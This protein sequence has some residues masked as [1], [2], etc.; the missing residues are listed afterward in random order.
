MRNMLQ[1]TSW[2]LIAKDYLKVLPPLRKHG[3]MY[4]HE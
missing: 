4:L 2:L 1:N 3:E